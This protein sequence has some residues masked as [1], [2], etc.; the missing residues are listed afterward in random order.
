MHDR[1]LRQSQAFDH[2]KRG[3]TTGTSAADRAPRARPQSRRANPAAMMRASAVLIWRATTPR[4][5]AFL[6]TSCSSERP[7]P[8]AGWPT[9]VEGA[10]VFGVG[11]RQKCN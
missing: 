10:L 1:Q 6:Q 4:S 7:P 8:R 5:R 3:R 9:A 11:Q 2:L